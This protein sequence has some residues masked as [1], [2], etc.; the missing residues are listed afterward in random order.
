MRESLIW[1]NALDVHRMGLINKWLFIESV[2]GF[3]CPNVE[4][5][6]SMICLMQTI[7]KVLSEADNTAIAGLVGL[8]RVFE[9]GISSF[10]ACKP[11]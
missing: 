11:D 1:I 7:E 5:R 6:S 2:L 3:V 10:S 8:K 9:S 4:T